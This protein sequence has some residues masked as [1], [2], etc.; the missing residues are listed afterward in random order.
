MFRIVPCFLAKFW[1]FVNYFRFPVQCH[2]TVP[3]R[4]FVRTGSTVSTCYGIVAIP[5]QRSVRKHYPVVWARG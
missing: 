4:F 3:P 5:A 1:C 2:P